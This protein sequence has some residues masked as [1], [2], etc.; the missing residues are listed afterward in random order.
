MANMVHIFQDN[1]MVG[2]LTKEDVLD[3]LHKK[4][5]ETTIE[6]YDLE[7]HGHNKYVEY[8]ADR[9]RITIPDEDGNLIEFIIVETKKVKGRTHTVRVLAKASYLQDIKKAKVIR[10]TTLNEYTV[11]MLTGW[12]LDGSDWRV[13]II[14]SD[15][16]RTMTI[17]NP[18]NPYEFLKRIANEFD[19]ELRF[20]VEHDGNKITGRFVDLL[21]RVG[22]W[23]GREVEFGHDLESIERNEKTND[24]VTCLVGYG[25]EDE[26]GN[27]LEVTVK[28]KEAIQRWGELWDYYEPQSSRLDM[29]ESELRQYTRTELDK[30]INA[31]VTY[32]ADIIDL[33]NV[34]GMENKK[35]RFGDT[36]HIKDLKFNP[37]LYLEAR[38]FEQRRSVFKRARKQVK[39]GDFTE[40]SQEEV[41][42]IWNQLRQQINQKIGMRELLERTYDKLTIDQKD[43]DVYE[44]GKTFAEAVGVDAKSY[45]DTQDTAL[46]TTVE[47]YADTVAGQAETNAKNH[48]DTVAGQAEANAKAYAVAQTVYDNQMQSI[49]DDLADKADITY[50]DGELVNKQAVIPQQT[51]AP[52]SPSSGDFWLDTSGSIDVLKRFNGTSWKKATPTEASEV[53]SYT[54]SEVDNMI[55]NTV[56]KTEYQTDMDGIVTDLTDHN[57]RIGQNETAIGL[58]ANQTEVDTLKGTVS[59]NSA[60]L[61]VQANQ[62]ASKVDATYVQGAI[63][64]VEIGGRNLL[65][66]N[67]NLFST[68]GTYGY[69]QLVEE[70]TELILKVYDKDTNVDMSNIY[71]GLTRDGSE[72]SGGYRWAMIN[73][74]LIRG[75]IKVS[76]YHYFSYFPNNQTT[77]NKIFERFNIKIEKGNKAT[78]W[79]PAPEDTQAQIDDIN[80]TVSS[81][82]T[83]ITQNATNIQEKADS[84]VVDG[85]ETRITSAESNING[86]EGAITTKVEQTT[87]NTLEGRVDTAEST[88]SQ[89]ANKIQSKIDDGEAR[90]IFT[91][92]A[93]SFTFDANQVNFTG[94]IFGEGASFAGNLSSKRVEIGGENP[95]IGYGQFTSTALEI[96]NPIRITEGS[97]QW[98]GKFEIAVGNN[99]ADFQFVDT[100]TI[101]DFN[102]WERSTF[103]GGLYTGDGPV[104]AIV[105]QGSNADGEYIRYANGIQICWHDIEHTNVST[106]R[107]SYQIDWFRASVYWY[108]PMPFVDSPSAHYSARV[109]TDG[110]ISL[111]PVMQ[112][113]YSKSTT[114]LASQ[115]VSP[116]DFNEVMHLSYFAIGRWK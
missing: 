30:R 96:K 61:N 87:F 103:F 33:E 36:I 116:D 45:A 89:H 107:S 17:E 92:E 47:G 100:S 94:H 20:R 15:N 18:T 106:S 46:K 84:T 44:D 85:L 91:Q 6:T 22:T 115:I 80:V 56:S 73:G 90:S 60:Q 95:N 111:A 69:Y 21:E 37:A 29:S 93:S 38:V 75:L 52:S 68:N 7:I 65:P 55:N 51:T 63:D 1:Q 72:S 49:A 31:V 67:F 86:L 4:S 11:S 81:H 97:Y 41:D 54:V 12:A 99:I 82:S 50:V 102:F 108:Y 114:R 27:R 19:L 113:I 35:I 101:S 78:D 23:Q 14:E 110:I 58:K 77:F 104:D 5:L 16:Y 74:E 112:R 66:T 3:D 105:D 70:D 109:S 59:D 83:Q 13:G 40:F 32:K 8:L 10:P 48:A 42:A 88:I 98:A 53:G 2:W 25:P 71:F 24:I 43:T 9:N 57:T 62:I 28:D 26:D 64:D 34:P 39:L 79:S 76:N